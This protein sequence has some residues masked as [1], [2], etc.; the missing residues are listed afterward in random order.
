M[1]SHASCR[2]QNTRHI[3]SYLLDH[4]LTTWYCCLCQWAQNH[5]PIHSRLAPVHLWPGFVEN[6]SDFEK[7]GLM[8]EKLII[9]SNLLGHIF[10][11]LPRE[12]V[13]KAQTAGTGTLF[14]Q[15]ERTGLLDAGQDH[16]NH[17]L[18]PTWLVERKFKPLHSGMNF[19][20]SAEISALRTSPKPIKPDMKLLWIS[21][22]VN[23][24]N[25]G[26]I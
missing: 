26:R 19:F 3:N 18:F 2:H 20:Y 14:F 10:P 21:L 12:S 15:I 23:K 9:V 25:Q 7:S 16:V 11:G 13:V 24:Q 4:Q 17:I 5:M 1:P 6:R 22:S 8:P